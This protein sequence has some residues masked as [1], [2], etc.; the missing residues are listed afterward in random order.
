MPRSLA[1]PFFKTWNHHMAYVLGYWFAD[2]NMYFQSGAGGYF[3]SIGSK[4]VEHLQYMQEVIGAGTLRQ[5]TRSEV[6]EL[7]ICRK[8]V[9]DDLL[10]L[11]GRVRKSL[12]LTWPSVPSEFLTDFIRGYID[13]DGSLDWKETQPR[14]TAVGSENFLMGMASAIEMTAGIAT[15][16]YHHHGRF[17]RI[18]RI[19]WY[20]LHAKCLAI[21]LYDNNQEPCLARKKAIA[22]DFIAWNPQIVRQSRITLKMRELFKEYLS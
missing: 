1:C 3:V 20:G 7:V 15:P 21:W 9:F 12:T 19:F 22:T 8:A 16:T 4:D 10:Q 11:G 18:G 6:Y 13:G 5:K 14:I 17:G 2:G